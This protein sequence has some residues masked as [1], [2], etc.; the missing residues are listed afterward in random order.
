MPA[1]KDLAKVCRSTVSALRDFGL[2][3]STTDD[4]NMLVFMPILLTSSVRIGQVATTDQPAEINPSSI[5]DQPVDAT[6][7]ASRSACL[8]A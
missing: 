8:N 5:V 3:A 7:S 2:H 4:A 6:P 1:T